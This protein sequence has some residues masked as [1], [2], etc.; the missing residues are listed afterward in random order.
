VGR[1][2]QDE[3]NYFEFNN[4]TYPDERE[5]KSNIKTKGIIL[6]GPIPIIF[7]FDKKKTMYIGILVI[8][9]FVIMMLITNY[10]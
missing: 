8:L 6:I 10:I 4:K 2:N 7:G 1:R 3:R 5:L 9:I